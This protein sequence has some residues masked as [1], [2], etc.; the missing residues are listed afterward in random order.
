MN[1]AELLDY[2]KNRQ[3]CQIC[4]VTSNLEQTLKEWVE[5]LK[6]GPWKIITLSNETITDAKLDGKKIKKPFKYYCAI[7]MFGNI[8]IEI[9]QPCYGPSIYKNF[10][11]KTNGG[12][13]HFKEKISDDML[14]KKLVEYKKVGIKP[15]F[16]GRFRE[17][18]FIN[19][20]T[21]EKLNFTFELGNFANI[22]LTED[23]YYTYPS[24]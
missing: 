4:L 15:I 17:D 11:K 12:L 1:C 14:N 19:L 18:I 10:L 22:T 7:S 13:H 9:I 16:S 3:I 20:D 5:V 21:Q 2:N 24:E 6:V 8:Q 23:M